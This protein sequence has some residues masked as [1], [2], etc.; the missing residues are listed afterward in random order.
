MPAATLRPRF[1]RL[2]NDARLP[3]QRF[4]ALRHAFASLQLE[5][6]EDI[7]TISKLL[8]HASLRTTADIYAHLS[9]K[10]QRR[11]AERMD[12]ILAG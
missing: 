5:A 12:K 1:T 11:A 4:H 10:T 3:H 9:P 8:G 6:G 7:V 2:L